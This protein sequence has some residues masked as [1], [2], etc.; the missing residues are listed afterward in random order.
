MIMITTFFLISMGTVVPARAQ[1]MCS[2]WYPVWAVCKATRGANQHTSPIVTP[3]GNP[4]PTG[5]DDGDGDGDGSEGGPGTGGH[6]HGHGHGHSG[7]GK[8]K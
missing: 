1:V 7:K 6:G 2:E 8:G 4:P 5:G 3:G